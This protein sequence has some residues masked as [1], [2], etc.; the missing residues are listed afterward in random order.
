MSGALDGIRVLEF[1]QI[2][3]GP[4]CGILL[5]DMGADVIKVEPPEGEA[6]R[7]SGAVVPNEGKYF[8]SLN[9]GKRSLTIDLSK[10]GA[11]ELV[12]RLIPS[13]DVVIINYRTGVAKRLGID[14]ATLSKLN[15][16]LVYANIT[17]FG[18]SGPHATRAGSDIVAQ[19]YSGL[20][21]AEAKTDDFGAPAPIVGTTLIDRVSGNAAAVG[22]CAALYHRERMGVGQEINISLLQT[23]LE[24][25]S[26][27]VMREPVQDVTV[28]DPFVAELAAKRASGAKYDEIVH[29]RRGQAPRFASHRL[30]YG[31]YHTKEG[32]LVLG[33]LTLQ[34]R[35]AA[36]KILGIDDETDS[37]EFNAAAP[38]SRARIEVWR[39]E[40]QERL[41]ERTADE[42]VAEFLAAGVPASTVNFA[43][44]MSEDVQVKATAMMVDLTHA[45]TGPQ[46]VVGPVV[47]MSATP[48]EASR[49]SPPLGGH[50]R[51]VLVEL[52]LSDAEVSALV[53]ER[54]VTEGPG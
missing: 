41:M 18:D 32:A 5:S 29:M 21:A 15:P 48:T 3:A 9:R 39:L 44:E 46:K 11:K 43:E 51:E 53:A 14:Y 8:Q 16:R 12:H 52:G 35:N 49:P 34:N 50:T 45:V 33:A 20:M 23:A 2:V 54:V 13:F 36:R 38:D 47:R 40:L 30:F 42:W 22:I 27:N 10:P 17:G 4:V 37:P 6:R 1:S 25:L 31:G 28:R 19:A 7:N 24:L 26:P